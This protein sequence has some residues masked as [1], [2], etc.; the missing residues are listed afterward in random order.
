MLWVFEQVLSLYTNR[1]YSHVSNFLCRTHRSE[2]TNPLLAP[3]PELMTAECPR[4][5]SENAGV[6]S[7]HDY[8]IQPRVCGSCSLLYAKGRL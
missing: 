3:D 8:Y 5:L 7:S 4:Q 1:P 2:V 6:F